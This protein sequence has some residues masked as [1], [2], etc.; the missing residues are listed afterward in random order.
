MLEVF[1]IDHA[2]IY[3]GDGKI[4]EGTIEEGSYVVEDWYNADD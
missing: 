1:V 2:N 4:M 3:T